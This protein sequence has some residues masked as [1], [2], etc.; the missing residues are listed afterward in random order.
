MLFIL[1]SVLDTV[2]LFNRLVLIIITV[3]NEV[4]FFPSRS[5]ASIQM[6]M[7]S[8]CIQ[9]CTVKVNLPIFQ[10]CIWPPL[11]RNGQVRHSQPSTAVPLQLSGAACEVLRS[12]ERTEG[13]CS[14]REH[15]SVFGFGLCPPWG[16][17]GEARDP[18]RLRWGAECPSVSSVLSTSNT[19]TFSIGFLSWS[20]WLTSA[21]AVSL[22]DAPMKKG[23]EDFQSFSSLR[24][25]DVTHPTFL[26]SGLIDLLS[27]M[28][29]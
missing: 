26:L 5:S 1:N 6:L 9:N 27:G 21:P 14:S 3:L 20:L 29:C 4:F 23:K 16:V 18:T 12:Q 7:S 19:L 11:S 8:C 10:A 17:C 24:V 28:I 13:V 22:E 2:H 15:P 25:P